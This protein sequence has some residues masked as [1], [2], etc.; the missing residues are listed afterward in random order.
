MYYID[1]P[2]NGVDAFDFKQQTGEIANR[3]TLV[4]M[5]D[6]RP[7][8]MAVDSDGF[9]WVAIPSHGQLRRY[10]PAGRLDGALEF[11]CRR[12]TSCCFGGDGL[13]DL[14]VTSARDQEPVSSGAQASPGGAIFRCRPGP[15]GQ[16]PSLFLTG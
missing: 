1:T 10:S 16:P 12:V 4:N 13:R 14:F 2:T 15:A 6:A 9:L 7:D 5:I 3:R 8:G 11:P